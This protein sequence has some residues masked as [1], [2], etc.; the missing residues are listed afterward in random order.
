MTE[1]CADQ[2][3]SGDTE[4]TY[5]GHVE[6]GVV[7]LD[8]RAPLP[9]GAAVVVA[10]ADDEAGLQAMREGLLKFAGV[11]KDMP[12][13]LARQHDHYIHGARRR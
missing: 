9:E 11:V 6:N 1:E 8:E 5:R 4:M 7:V 2:D 10:P 3:G 12:H 13:D